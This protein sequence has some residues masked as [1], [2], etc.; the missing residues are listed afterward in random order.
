MVTALYIFCYLPL[1]ARWYSHPDP[2][3][4]LEEARGSTEGY[5]SHITREALTNAVKVAFNQNTPRDFQLDVAEALILGLDPTVVAG[6]GP[7]KTLPWIGCDREARPTVSM[8]SRTD[9]TRVVMLFGSPTSTLSFAV[10]S[11]IPRPTSG[12]PSAISSTSS[13]PVRGGKDDPIKSMSSSDKGNVLENILCDQWG[14]GFTIYGQC[15]GD[16]ALSIHSSP[17]VLGTFSVAPDRILNPER[18]ARD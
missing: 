17:D 15:D 12:W 1:F 11:L 3:N 2:L 13:M 16:M 5:N 18:L 9:L 14:S 7:G 10:H 8:R 6:T 4:A